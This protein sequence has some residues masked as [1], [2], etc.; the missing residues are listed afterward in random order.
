MSSKANFEKQRAGRRLYR[1]AKISDHQFRQVL[2]SFA[3]D[4]TVTEAAQKIR[5]S[6]T[7]IH[8]IYGKLRSFFTQSGLF[9]DPYRGGDPR[10]GLPEGEEI[11]EHRLINYYLNRNARKRGLPDTTLDEVDPHWNESHWRFHY[12]AMTEGQRADS[13]DRMMFSHLLAH[14]RLCG[15][16]GAKPTNRRKGLELALYQMDERILWMERNA[17]KYK[18]K[19]LKDQL[20]E[21]YN[22]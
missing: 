22:D 21:I 3:R 6:I 2:W 12:W 1:S 4:E 11:F 10:N 16:V 20:R 14:I 8:A 13:V 17:P 15:P 19:S 18:Q 5:L 9:T 7:S